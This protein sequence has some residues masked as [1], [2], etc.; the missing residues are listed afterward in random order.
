MADAT[1]SG[2]ARVRSDLSDRHPRSVRSVGQ[3]DVDQ[4]SS[5]PALI[6]AD[7]RHVMLAALIFDTRSGGQHTP[8]LRDHN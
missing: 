2:Y 6:L 7:R 8:Q 4:R 3:L 5:G 1:F